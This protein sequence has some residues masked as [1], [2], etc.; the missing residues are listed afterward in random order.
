MTQTAGRYRISLQLLTPRPALPGI[1]ILRLHVQPLV[2]KGNSLEIIVNRRRRHTDV[3]TSTTLPLLSS[4]L[5]NPVTSTGR[6]VKAKTVGPLRLCFYIPLNLRWQGNR[7]G[8][9]ASCHLRQ[10]CTSQLTHRSAIANSHLQRR[11]STQ[12]NS[13]AQPG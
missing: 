6:L 12:L 9:A 4:G 7:R 8:A 5:Q 13:T 11:D 1:I 2:Q 10:Q 3:T